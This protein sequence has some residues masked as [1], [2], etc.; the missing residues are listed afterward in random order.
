MAW[1]MEQDVKSPYEMKENL[2]R[3]LVAE[4][5]LVAYCGLFCGA[6]GAYRK[7]RCPGCAGNDKASWCKIRGCCRQKNIGS[8]AE[9]L[10]FPGV[11]ECKKFNNLMSKIFA[12]LFKS[13]RSACIRQIREIGRQGHAEKMA[14]MKA[15]TIRKR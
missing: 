11:M 12:A 14:E 10:E 7:G 2:V 13:D 15:Q 9:C 1:R 5:S 3:E 4:Q 6:C 8:C